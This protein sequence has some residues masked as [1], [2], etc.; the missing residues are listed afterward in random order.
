MSLILQDVILFLTYAFRTRTLIRKGTYGRT[1]VL[2][3]L[4]WLSI[5]IARPHA[6]LLYILG[7]QI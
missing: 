6:K 5:V 2:V 7:V 1:L 3:T 4:R